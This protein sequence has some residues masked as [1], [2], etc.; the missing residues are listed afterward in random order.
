MG[1]EESGGPESGECHAED[2][3]KMPGQSD[4]PL[5]YFWSSAARGHRM[6]LAENFHQPQKGLLPSWVHP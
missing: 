4:E 3:D 5:L 1:G 2:Y 6:C